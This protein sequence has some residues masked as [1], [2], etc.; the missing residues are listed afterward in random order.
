LND[1]ISGIDTG[2]TMRVPLSV[3]ITV[4]V[5]LPFTN[6]TRFKTEP[7]DRPRVELLEAEHGLSSSVGN[8]DVQAVDALLTD[9][10][11]IVGPDG[12]LLDKALVLAAVR[13]RDEIMGA[14][15]MQSDVRFYDA[16][17]LVHGRGVMSGGQLYVLRA[18]VRLAGGWRL[19]VEHATDITEHATA[20][21]PAFATLETP[22]PARPAEDAPDEGADEADVRNALRESHE[23]YW[24]K[25]VQ[26]YERT[27][28][29]DL[30]RAAET[31]VRPGTELVAFMKDSPHL[32]RQPSRQLEMWAKVF[33]NVAIGGW[34]DAGTTPH[35]AVTRNRFTLALVW[36]D[37]RWQI[38]QIQST[39]VQG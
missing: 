35:G 27:V 36:R 30:I 28:G 7:E 9:G 13:D 16:V 18:W 21:P 39:A 37:G 38:V 8:R 3:L 32:P 5:L 19:A 15:L 34:L 2:V 1:H 6:H 26:G 23:R 10:I 17:A 20:D 22:V 14:S 4:C 33:G 25:D 24:A 29:A 12:E 11:R 31:G